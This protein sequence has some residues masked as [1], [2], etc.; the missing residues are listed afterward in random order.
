MKIYACA[1]GVTVTTI[2]GN[3]RTTIFHNKAITLISASFDEATGIALR[4]CREVYPVHEKY[5]N[6]TTSVVEVPTN[7]YRIVEERS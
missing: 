7:W 5:T 1:I 2:D 4:I 6:H 3:N